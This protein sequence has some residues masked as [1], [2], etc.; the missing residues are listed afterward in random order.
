MKV[1]TCNIRNFGAEDGENNW[2]HRKEV[3]AEI[4]R[5]QAPDIICFQEMWSQQF[6]D[7]AISLAEYQ[8]YAVVDE[9]VGRHPKNCMFY[10][11]EA[12]TLISAGGY[13][14]SENPH[15]AGTKS[16]QSACVRL[17]NWIRLEDH[18]TGTEFRIINTHLDHVSQTAR[19]NQARLIV[20]D[21]SAYPK[22]YPQI[23]TGDMNCDSTNA[24]IEVFRAGGWSDT[25]DCVHGTEDPGYTFHQF[26]GPKYNSAIGKIDWIFMRGRMKAITAEIITDSTEGRF[27]SD[28]YFVSAAVI[29]QKPGDNGEQGAPADTDKPRR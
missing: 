21:S 15:V 16:W 4:I 27:P 9:P 28:H 10:R 18:S 29:A 1:L 6:A 23:L 17:A 12:Y 26:L 22:D 14:L 25:Y 5:S 19:E 13:W 11:L 7:M 24:A 8:S 20:A 3:C 2:T